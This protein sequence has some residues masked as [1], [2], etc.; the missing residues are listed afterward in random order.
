[1]RCKYVLKGG[2][3]ACRGCLPCSI[4]LRRMWTN[5]IMLE[6]KL[7]ASSSFLTLTY[8]DE[9]LPSDYSVSPEEFSLFL[10]RFRKSLDQR[11]IRYFAVGEYGEQFAR[12]HYHAALFGVGPECLP[13][14]HAT[15]RKCD[16]RF[17]TLTPLI[18]ERAQYLAGYVTKKMTDRKD[19]RLQGR[20]PQFARMSRQNGG[21]GVGYI[22]TVAKNI[23][24]SPHAME[25]LELEGD[26]PQVLKTGGRT[27][28]IGRYLRDNLR[29]EVGYDPKSLVFQNRKEAAEDARFYAQ[30]QLVRDGTQ[31]LAQFDALQGFVRNPEEVDQKVL[32]LEGSQMIKKKRQ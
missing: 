1:M 29:K 25:I 7:H 19:P 5:R 23:L 14:V 24:T 11:K 15:W 21:I 20:H 17:A 31:T 28:P 10:K 3:W 4:A 30:M 18:L 32:N 27:L 6:S 22:K 16:P 12:P 26:V 9:N 8:D 2:R 13:Q